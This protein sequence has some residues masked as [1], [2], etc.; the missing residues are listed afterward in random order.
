MSLDLNFDW[1]LTP[2]KI[3]ITPEVLYPLGLICGDRM[4]FVEDQSK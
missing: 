4:E 2:T 3:I 1:H